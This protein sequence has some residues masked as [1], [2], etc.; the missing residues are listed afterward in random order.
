MM[1][2][3]SDTSTDIKNHNDTIKHVPVRAHP[4]I[5]SF[6]NLTGGASPEV[7]SFVDRGLWSRSHSSSKRAGHGVSAHVENFDSRNV[8][9]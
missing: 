5:H 4:K 8:V 6:S 9:A 2:T 1:Q 3:K 7:G